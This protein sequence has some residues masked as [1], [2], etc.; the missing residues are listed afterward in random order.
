MQMC[1]L[2]RGTYYFNERDCFDSVVSYRKCVIN[3]TS[4]V[5]VVGLRLS[6]LTGVVGIQCLVFGRG[7]DMM[8]DA[9]TVADLLIV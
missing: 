5:T 3:S 4:Y 8:L 7:Y 1:A 6:G 9:Q 2:M